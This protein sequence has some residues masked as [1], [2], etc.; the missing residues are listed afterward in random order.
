MIALRAGVAKKNFEIPP[1]FGMGGYGDRQSGNVGTHD[2]L[3]TKSLAL[4][5]GKNTLVIITNDLLCIDREMTAIIRNKIRHQTGIPE[6][7]ILVCTSH[8]HSGPD[9]NTD[10]FI[11]IAPHQATEELKAALTN[12]ILENALISR[13]HMRPAGLHFG[14]SFCSEIA[15]NRIDAALPSDHSVSALQVVDDKKETMAVLINYTC[16]PTVLGA[17]NLLIS[18][19][20]PGAAER[21]LEEHFGGKA[22]ALFTNGACGNQSTRFT[23]KSQDFNEVE[24]MGSLLARSAVEAMENAAIC[25]DVELRA[26]SRMVELPVRKLPSMKE[27]LEH[28]KEAEELKDKA[29]AEN[30]PSSEIRLAVTRYQGAYV[31]VKMIES[32][33]LYGNLTG[34]IQVLKIGDIELIGIPV[35]LFVEYGLAMKQKSRSKNPIIVGY[36]NDYL[37]YVYTQKEAEKGGYEVWTSPF[38]AEAGD[39]LVE[40]VLSLEDKLY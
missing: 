36:A 35:E 10:G 17:D 13:E 20:F 31:T 15:A 40:Q 38:A 1:G 16:H 14:R 28:L 24:R 37:G 29:I 34:E 11:G 18:A 39:V 3:Y 33:K 12:T 4:N 27:A 2:S 25:G 8:T 6:Y 21:M 19:D 32:G 9:L 30:R 26:A 5:D 23:R 7:N 22:V